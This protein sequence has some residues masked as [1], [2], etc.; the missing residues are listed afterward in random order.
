MVYVS[1]LELQQYLE[2]WHYLGEEVSFISILLF[3]KGLKRM[4]KNNM[5][6]EITACT[7]AV[8]L[9]LLTI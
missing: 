1:L 2:W 7:S 3:A 6:K 8:L 9:C 5:H 4:M